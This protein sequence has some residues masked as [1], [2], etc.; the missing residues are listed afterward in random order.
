M[1]LNVPTRTALRATK[2]LLPGAVLLVA[3]MAFNYLSQPHLTWPT[4]GSI[5]V[6]PVRASASTRVSGS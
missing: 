1:P 5:P 4:I 6:S 2:L 3:A